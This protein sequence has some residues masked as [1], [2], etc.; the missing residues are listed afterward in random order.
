MDGGVVVLWS[1]W[2]QIWWRFIGVESYVD[3]D[4]LQGGGCGALR[5]EVVLARVLGSPS[6]VEGAGGEFMATTASSMTEVRP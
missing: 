2:G 6:M 1:G 4:S 5:A 3:G